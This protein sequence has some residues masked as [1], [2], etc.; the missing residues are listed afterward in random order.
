VLQGFELYGDITFAG[1]TPLRSPRV[2]NVIGIDWIFNDLEGNPSEYENYIRNL[3]EEAIAEISRKPELYSLFDE[4]V[5]KKNVDWKEKFR[6]RDSE[7]FVRLSHYVVYKELKESLHLEHG[8]RF[9]KLLELQAQLIY[10]TGWVGRGAGSKNLRKR[11]KEEGR[12]R[13]SS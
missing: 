1:L 4:T 2:G 13:S 7:V 9:E 12:Y 8:E 10:V 11:G 3:T 6:D 5:D